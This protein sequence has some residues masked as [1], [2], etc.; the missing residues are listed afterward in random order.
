MRLPTNCQDV[1][2]PYYKGVLLRSVVGRFRPHPG[3]GAGLR[4]LWRWEQACL[5]KRSAHL[6]SFG[7]VGLVD[8]AG[9]TEVG[10]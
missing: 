1:I 9:S 8:M 3:P 7:D 4:S 2:L 6:A 10:A 5:L